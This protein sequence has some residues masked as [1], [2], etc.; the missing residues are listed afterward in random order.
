[1]NKI[2]IMTKAEMLKK[3]NIDPNEEQDMIPMTDWY[4]MEFGFMLVIG[5]FRNKEEPLNEEYVVILQ[6]S[7]DILKLLTLT[8]KYYYYENGTIIKKE[9]ENE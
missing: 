5:N 2:E 1:M 9:S 6:S 8:E 4:I 7:A 3:Y